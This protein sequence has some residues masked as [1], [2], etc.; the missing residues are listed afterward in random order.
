MRTE[1]AVRL[2]LV[3]A[4]VVLLAVFA[5][6]PARCQEVT[7]SIVGTITDSTGA[8]LVN[9]AVSAKDTQ[10]GT[11]LDAKT[12]E[13]GAYSITR[14]PVGTY[15]VKVTATGF[16]T[17]IYPAFTL[18][19]N[20]T[21]RVDVQLKVGKV[22][23]TVEV[24]AATAPVLQTQ[25]TEVSTLFD[26]NTLT[27]VPLAA[28]NYIQLTL[29]APGATTVNPESMQLPQNMLN[30]GRPYINGNR[31]QANSFLLDGQINN[32]SK[33]NETAYNP[34]LDA[35]QEFNLITQNAKAEFGNYQ[36]GVVSATI[37]SGTN[38][39]HGSAFEFF[40]N[41]ALN[42][43]KYFSGMTKGLPAF[44]GAFGH[45]KD[46]ST[47]KPAFRY[48]Q[49]GATFGGPI[50]KDKLF[51][52]ADYQG[53]RRKNIG[54]TGAQL[55]TTAARAGNFAELCTGGFDSNNLCKDTALGP[56]ALD[57][58]SQGN[59][60]N[61]AVV[62]ANQLVVPGSGG[63]NQ[64]Y[65]QNPAQIPAM[66]NNHVA[67][68]P[69]AVLGNNLPGAGLTVSPAV[70]NL[71][72]SKYY[73]APQIDKLLVGNNYFF[74]SGD[75]LNNDQGDLKID[76]YMSSKDNISGRWSQMNLRNPSFTT[77]T[78]FSVG[79]LIDDPI[80]NAVV[81]WRHTFSPTVVNEFRIGFGAVHYTQSGTST[82][83]LGKFSEQLGITGGNAQAP[84]M[85]QL[86][87]PGVGT[88]NPTLGSIDAVQIFHTTEG[89][90]EDNLSFVHGRHNFKAGFQYWRERQDYN[91]GGNNG[92]LGYLSIN[93]ATN[94]GLADFWMGNVGGGFRDGLSNTVF[95]LRGNIFAFYG[96]DDWRVT[97]TFTLNLGM[98]FEDHTPFYE[99]KDREVN[100]GFLTGAIEQAGQ[101]GNSRA[102]YN[103]Y[104]G[105][106]DW[107]PR[108]GLSWS[109]AMWGGRTVIRA[110]Y[111]VSTYME[112]G[113]ANEELTQNPPFY[114]AAETKL[115]GDISA[116]FGP[117]IPPCAAINIACYSGI[118]IRVTDPN[119]RPAV[120][121]QWNLT[122]Q[123]QFTNSLTFQ[124]G[125]VGQ[126]GTHLLNFGQIAQMRGLNAQ[127][128][129]AKPGEL[130]VSRVAGPYLGGAT[131][132]SLNQLDNSALGGSNAIAGT[133]L[134]NSS[135]RYDALQAVLKNRMYHGLEA[136]VAYTY[137]K[138]L[139][140]SPGY[141]GTGW[142]SSNA[143]SSGGQPG[144]QNMYDGR[145]DWGPCYW[146]QKHV[147]TSYVTYDLPLGRGKQF[148]KDMNPALNAVLGNWEIGGIITL[149]TGNALTLNEFG[150]WG[151]FNGDPSNTNGIG[152]YFL[153][154]RP[155][156][157]GPLHNV[158]QYTA[159]NPAT[160]TPGS[161]QWFDGSTVSE[162][163]ANTFGTCSVGNGRGPGYADFDMNLHKGIQITERFRAELRLE[164]IN[165]FNH[166]V[167]T[168]SAG[169]AGGSFDKGSPVFGQVT[170]SQGARQLQLALRFTF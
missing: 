104:L 64:L 159:P 61:T 167:L 11:Q 39:F 105:K 6:P 102:L 23:E 165:A 106:G 25:S 28:R 89:Q 48:N 79:G 20:Q 94:V 116:G 119:F 41:D 154:A 117:S 38:G 51:F 57:L 150:G 156:C 132:G 114:G 140:N 33:N 34:G 72:N 107:N 31:E 126:H 74:T 46:G 120:V 131:V 162:A 50:I 40:R 12:N 164:A 91:Y 37:K 137:S 63:A 103:N 82:D 58:D 90:L 32:E 101:N 142:G 21:A 43:N 147:L 145:A 76:Y 84:G 157:N 141:F 143:L 158:N 19:L 5:V 59:P 69:T 122:L 36:G 148:G 62:L 22:T 124:V 15:E 127:G 88:G 10:R 70:Q 52:F 60:K 98:R 146:D 92:Q 113:G 2:V 29:L 170:G 56:N 9:A 30:S 1:K 136:Q 42:A 8:P 93:T 86:Q 75:N 35:I 87:I 100:F 95:G 135:Q 155:S 161:I 99:I 27:A 139:S 144:W 149:H 128:T 115:P 16:Q 71:L 67:K 110:G 14:V 111:G 7:A 152:A 134:S 81:N 13:T 53:Q 44:E 108:I 109:P 160:N 17:A 112:G 97:N 54:T 66:I 77:L 4:L 96:Q 168:F 123:H 130:I 55:L 65:Y 83:F 163:A 47:I 169:P 166:R 151:A 133:N 118:R 125:Y 73:P 138:C 45:N 85:L 78:L 80:R 24:T 153:S 18:V 3:S 49:F 26:A 129:L 68:Q 121:Q